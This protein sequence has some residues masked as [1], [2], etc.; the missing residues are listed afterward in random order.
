MRTLYIHIGAHKTGTTSIQHT[1]AHS[2]ETLAESDLRY[3]E[4][5]WFHYAQH[6]LA[7]AM[8]GMEDPD[9]G[10]VP[11]LE[12][13]L[14]VL[15]EAV[16]ASSGD[17][18]ISSEELFS[19]PADQVRRLA[20]FC[21]AQN[22]QGRIVAFIRRQDTLFASMYN[23]EAKHPG[24][25]F[26]RPVGQF[27]KAPTTL[28]A[29]LDLLGCLRAWADAFGRE[30]ITVHRYEVGDAMGLFCDAI[31]HRAEDVLKP[32]KRVN[33]SV[34]AATL[35]LVR[36]A[37]FAGAD[38]GVQRTI[39]QEAQSAFPADRESALLTHKQAHEVLS[40]FEADNRELF[41][42][43]ELGENVYS[44]AALSA[45]DWPEQPAFNRMTMARFM[46]HLVEAHKASTPIAEAAG[47]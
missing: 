26:F 12:A 23:Q 2:A 1:L 25:G 37:K 19:A 15:A 41:E 29:D 9:K 14:S 47:A 34:S 7:F 33:R 35:E 13:E 6:R 16:S 8:K 44:P 39:L 5:C 21:K 36:L 10:D 4:I 38:A 40:Y 31:G 30:Q 3:P 22:L 24:N 11:E 43:F 17:L 46:V 27:T 28:L 45:E 32:G 18:I 42:T 20:D